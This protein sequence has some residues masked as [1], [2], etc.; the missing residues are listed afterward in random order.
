MNDVSRPK[1][2]HA[3][4]PMNGTADGGAT[5]APRSSM[6]RRLNVGQMIAAPPE[7]I[8]WI[9]DRLV[10]KGGLTLLAGLAGQGKSLVTQALAMAAVCPQGGAVAGIE[11][12]PGR[13]LIVDA[14]NGPSEIHRRVHVLGLAPEHATRLEIVE[15]DGFHLGRDLDAL[16]ALIRE[17]NPD[18]A[19]L[20]GFRS[21]WWVGDENKS[22]DV[23]PVL[24]SLR[25]LVRRRGVGTI[26]IHHSPKSGQTYRGSS[27]IAASVELAFILERADGDDDRQ[28]RRLRCE[29]SRP[30]PEPAPRWLRLAAEH[31][32]ASGLPA[33]RAAEPFTEPRR[34]RAPVAVGLAA[35]AVSLVTDRGPMPR[36]GIAHALG[37]QPSD[38][39]IRRAV[40]LAVNE[41][42]LVRRGDGQYEVAS[43]DGNA[44]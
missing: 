28:R 32:L 8:P 37:R 18:L 9:V 36:A 41:G 26:L 33:I 40:E 25:N 23:A 10:V 17:V 5:P 24:S 31:E 38:G 43:H 14:E 27:A 34:E 2:A 21:L 3:Q 42:T 6:L 1:A 22:E 30:A 44:D 35:E 7:P 15:A 12:E 11:V 16:D 4:R 20:D 39:T 29:K 19:I 13:V